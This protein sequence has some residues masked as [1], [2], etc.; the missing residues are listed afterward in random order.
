MNTYLTFLNILRYHIN[1][2]T[3]PLLRK[4]MTL[5]AVAINSHKGSLQKTDSYTGIV[6]LQLA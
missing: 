5:A 6:I 1:R 3:I 2:Q 4:K